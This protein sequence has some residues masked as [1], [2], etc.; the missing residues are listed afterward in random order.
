MIGRHNRSGPDLGPTFDPRKGA[1]RSPTPRILG[2]SKG[3]KPLRFR[4]FALVGVE[5][6][7]SL[8]RKKPGV[9]IPSPPPAKTLVITS[10]FSIGQPAKALI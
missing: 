6:L 10:V 7:H 3:L 4:A 9:Q 2:G 8:A 5:G 1:K